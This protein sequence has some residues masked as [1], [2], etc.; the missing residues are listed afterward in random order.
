MDTSFFANVIMDKQNE[1][2]SATKN[3]PTTGTTP[4]TATNKAEARRRSSLIGGN[5]GKGG[6]FYARLSKQRRS[7]ADRAAEF[8]QQYRVQSSFRKFFQ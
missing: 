1:Q 6:E 8:Q 3:F 2:S 5:D 7:S 4:T